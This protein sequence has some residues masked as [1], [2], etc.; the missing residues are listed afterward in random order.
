MPDAMNGLGVL[1]VEEHRAAEAAAWFERAL[2][3]SPG[4]VE[5]RLNLGIALHQSGQETRAAEQ[6]R[7]VL[8]APGA[9]REKAAAVKLLRALEGR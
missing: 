8:A 6:Y 3:A 5:A 7:R 4:F 9:A 2:Q 1:L